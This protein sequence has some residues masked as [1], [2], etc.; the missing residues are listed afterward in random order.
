MKKVIFFLLL[1]LPLLAC[2]Q[3]LTLFDSL[4]SRN[5][6][7]RIGKI[8]DDTSSTNDHKALPTL[9]AVK[10]LANRATGIVTLDNVLSNGSTSSRTAQVGGLNIVS[11]NATLLVGS[12]TIPGGYN[13]RILIDPSKGN[14]TFIPSN[15]YTNFV[16]NVT[17]GV[18]AFLGGAS[19][20]SR[21]FLSLGA[22]SS[23]RIGMHWTPPIGTYIQ[24][25]Q[26]GDVDFTGEHLRMY[27]NGAWKNLDNT[28]E[29]VTDIAALEN[30]IGNATGIHVSDSLRGGDF[31]YKTSGVTPDSGT[32]FPS[33]MGGYW[34]REYNH[35]AGVMVTWFGAKSDYD[36][37][38]RTGSDSKAAIQLAINSAATRATTVIFPPGRGG[39]VY[40][41]SDSLVV[42]QST[43]L[44]GTV[45]LFP[46]QYTNNCTDSTVYNN[47]T[48]LFFYNATNGIVTTATEVLNYRSQ[49]I[50]I[51]GLGI[52][53]NGKNNGKTG[54]V[55]RVTSNATTPGKATGLGTLLYVYFAGW[56][57]G[58]DGTGSTDS[59]YVTN[60]H[61]SDVKYGLIGGTGQTY[62]LNS[63]FY[64]IEI[65]GFISNSLIGD[66]VQFGEFETRYATDAALV[67][68]GLYTIATNC[69]FLTNAKSVRIN[70]T[71]SNVK[72]NNNQFFANGSTDISADSARYVEIY[73]NKIKIPGFGT[74]YDANCVSYTQALSTPRIYARKVT[75]LIMHDNDVVDSSF[76][77]YTGTVA[78]IDTSTTAFNNNH[79]TG[80]TY[81]DDRQIT[82]TGGSI[83][84]NADLGDRIVGGNVYPSTN[85]SKNLGTSNNIWST[86]YAAN[87]S[88]PSGTALNISAFGA[89]SIS[90]SQ[91]GTQSGRFT[92]SGQFILGTGTSTS[93]KLDVTGNAAISGN[94][95]AGKFFVSSLNTAPAS[96]SDVG[97]V[98]E[99]R[100]TSSGIYLC[101]A[102]NTWLKFTG[103]GSF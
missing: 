7:A 53:G 61:F 6:G 21:A 68:N 76:G 22:S 74:A 19:T 52:F 25:P 51:E 45:S 54:I 78:K 36:M 37:K 34:V 62:V 86:L 89:N 46:K 41:C 1:L 40:G 8:I 11:Q 79:F 80:F 26:N 97:T 64:N 100:L 18:S 81:P 101:I 57:I 85:N 17:V 15:G 28:G 91:N 27:I 72:L 102:T 4:Q 24:T 58:A 33:I 56:N 98:G 48:A 10:R 93:N 42:G 23:N 70:Y 103:S 71:A 84:S 31:Y 60:C 96:S 30:W 16:D 90:F 50:R 55:M 99:L 14:P 95:T 83:F 13:F 69:L 49:G 77:G 63:D 9:Y 73:A 32:V 66:I 82:V 75:G 67:I 20:D 59:W 87:V 92:G 94:T 5:G 12:D 35:V 44:K 43:Y 47:Q 3:T 88:V 29:T 65:A 39:L 2:T 38:L